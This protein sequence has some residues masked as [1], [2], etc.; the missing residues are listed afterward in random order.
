MIPIATTRITVNRT[1]SADPSTAPVD[2]YGSG[3]PGYNT[4][5]ITGDPTSRI[6]ARHVRAHISAPSGSEII[7]GGQQA[8]VLFR[9]TADPCD[10]NHDDTVTDET[11]GVTYQVNWVVPR[12]GLTGLEHV[13]GAL[14][15]VEGLADG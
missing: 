14:V 3:Y 13:E 15:L 5:V 9:L 12:S 6:T 10:I 8:R 4:T 7:V 2:P 1:D 11:T